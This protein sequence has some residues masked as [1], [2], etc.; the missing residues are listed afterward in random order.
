[1]KTFL[2]FLFAYTLSQFFRSFLA[3]VAPEL[4][5]ELSLQADDLGII[6]A[7]WFIAF[8]LAQ[9]PVGWLLDE[10]GPRRSV[11]GLM[12]AA[13]AGAAL[14]AAADSL[15]MCVAAMILIG[16]G[17][18]PVYM[19][20]LY[21]FAR[22]EPDARFAFLASTLIG[23]GSVGNL[24]GATPLAWA[25]TVF[26]WRLS[27]LLIAGLTLLAGLLI[28]LLIR[29]P[30]RPAES[31]TEQRPWYSELG[32]ILRVRQL[33]PI[34]PIAAISYAV[35]AAE[36]G[37]WVGPYFA[38]VHNLGPIPR[39]DAVLAMAVAMSL[40]A[41]AYG[42]LDQWFGT[43][44]WIAIVGTVATGALFMLLASWTG[45]STLQATLLLAAIGGI[46]LTY[47]V[48][49]AHARAFL[50]KHL[51]GRGITLMNFLFIGGAGLIQPISGTIAATARTNGVPPADI[52]ATLH[53]GFGVALLVVALI[54]FLS[55]D[56]APSR[57]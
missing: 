27:F 19:G 42:P 26:G 51:M 22:T 38:E 25:M 31:G 11:P 15:W 24:L 34:M 45:A 54:Y 29:D 55:E 36:R 3:V 57:E 33:W 52:Y 28:Y 41:I 37:L 23:I 56:R 50:P 20:A 32:E 49:M 8:A 5:A 13:V 12:L 9:F 48:I 46:G 2:I 40:G 53:W 4:A 16:I 47:G 17:C 35:V 18:A 39:G 21:I 43:R 6:S 10:V 30:E 44:K 7:S 1:M 14:F